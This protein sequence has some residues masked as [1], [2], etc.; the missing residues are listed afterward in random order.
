VG[1]ASVLGK[2]KFCAHQQK[3]IE[4]LSEGLQKASAQLEL[5]KPAPQA[6]LNNR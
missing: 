6:I 5:N 4:T 2:H 1:K 3:Q